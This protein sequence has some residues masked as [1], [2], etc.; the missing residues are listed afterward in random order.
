MWTMPQP[1]LR[2]VA[3]LLLTCAVGAF[4]LGILGAEPR[5]GRLPGEGLAEGAGSAPMSATDAQ[6]LDLAAPESPPVVVIEETTETPAPAPPAETAPSDPQTPALQV[7]DEPAPAPRSPAP[8][9]PAPKAPTPPANGDAIGDLVD[10][11]SELPP[12]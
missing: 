12:F 9:A 7:P 11:L 2:L 8:A 4:V 3:L 1:V 10:G 6:A 5:G